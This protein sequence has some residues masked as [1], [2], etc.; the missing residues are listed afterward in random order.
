M[1]VDQHTLRA[2]NI[3]KD[4]NES[5]NNS[6]YKLAKKFMIRILIDMQYLC[7]AF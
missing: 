7:V 4:G 3:L 2:I 6:S 1:T 5:P